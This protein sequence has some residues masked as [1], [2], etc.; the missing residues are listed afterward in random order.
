MKLFNCIVSAACVAVLSG[1]STSEVID[2]V[3]SEKTVIGFETHMN[4]NS[5]A[6]DNSNFRTFLVFGTYSTSSSSQPVQVFFGDRV[7]KGTDGVWKCST[8]RYWTPDN[9][10]DFYAYSCDNDDID[11][12]ETGHSAMNGK[13]LNLLDYTITQGHCDHDLVYAAATGEHRP[14]HE[15]GVTPEPV[16]LAFKHILTRLKFTFTSEIPGDNYTVKISNVKLVNFRNTGNFLGSSQSWTEQAR[17]GGRPAIS[18]TIPNGG[19]IQSPENG[20]AKRISL[21]TEPVYM[22]PFSYSDANVQIEFDF[23]IEA[24][25]SGGTMQE[26]MRN[27]IIGTWQPNWVKGYSVNNKITL[28]GNDTGMDAIAFTGSIVPDAEEGWT[29][30]KNDPVFTFQTG[31]TN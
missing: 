16:S 1:C 13:Y 26:V 15:D 18:L 11:L 21:S 31:V 7:T 14:A 12:A 10:Y 5:R 27:H 30:S 3:K 4:K 17:S 9:Y 19:I 28:T 20:E 2:D 8:T 25:N 24:P 23:S 29:D 22:I 6:L